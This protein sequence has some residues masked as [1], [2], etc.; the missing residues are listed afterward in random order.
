MKPIQMNLPRA[1]LCGALLALAIPGC[2]TEPS[3][4]GGG[5]LAVG[6]G[7]EFTI[8]LQ[9]IGPG[10][11]NPPAITPV[12][13]SRIQFLSVEL[14][15]PAVPAGVTQLFHFKAV[16]AG[17]AILDFHSTG[18]SATVEDTVNVH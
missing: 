13:T 11:Y 2:G 18:M 3:L 7:D 10:E 16:S 8:R 17:R 5:T 12:M 1:A 15:G 6:S 9:H 14:V 4:V